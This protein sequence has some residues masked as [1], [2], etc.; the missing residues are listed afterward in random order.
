MLW[1][2]WADRALNFGL[3]KIFV[4]LYIYICVCYFFY[5]YIKIS[6]LSAQMLKKISNTNGL[7]VGHFWAD[8]G[9][10]GTFKKSQYIKIT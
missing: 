7:Y 10:L 6:A 8:M 2:A 5:Y 1:A 9:T 3:L 4:L